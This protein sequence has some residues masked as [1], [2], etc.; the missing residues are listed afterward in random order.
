MEQRNRLVTPLHD[1]GVSILYQERGCGRQGGCHG[2]IP[3]ETCLE[4][5]NKLRNSE[6]G[7]HA[8]RNAPTSL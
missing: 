4:R 7:Y 8:Q 6:R 2:P 1:M 5:W 3:L